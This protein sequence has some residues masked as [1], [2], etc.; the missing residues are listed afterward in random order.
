M[1]FSEDTWPS[2]RILLLVFLAS[3][4]LR[5][6]ACLHCQ[7]PIFFPMITCEERVSPPKRLHYIENHKT[8]SAFKNRKITRRIRNACNILKTIR[9]QAPVR[10]G[11]SR[12]YTDACII[13]KS[14]RRP[15]ARFT[16]IYPNTDELPKY[17]L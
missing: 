6:E 11:R 15:A 2:F 3:F 14:T 12:A 7:Q 4:L 5:G 8:S 10:L 16:Q 13:L 9:R 1:P 17:R